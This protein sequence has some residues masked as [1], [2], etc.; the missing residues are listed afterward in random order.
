MTKIYVVYYYTESCCCRTAI[1]KVFTTEAQANAYAY[2]Q[3]KN[4]GRTYD[5]VEKEIS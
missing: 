5:Y 3:E 4:T 1:D 2:K